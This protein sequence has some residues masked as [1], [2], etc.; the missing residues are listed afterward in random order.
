MPTSTLNATDVRW[1]GGVIV[2]ARGWLHL[3]ILRHEAMFNIGENKKAAEQE[4]GE[5]FQ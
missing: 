2:H 3:K 1:V 4:L 5:F